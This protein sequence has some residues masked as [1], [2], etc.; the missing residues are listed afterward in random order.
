VFQKKV[1]NTTVIISEAAS[2]ECVC[3]VG[4]INEPST[5]NGVKRKRKV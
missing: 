5:S 2:E 3:D 4:Q 1:S